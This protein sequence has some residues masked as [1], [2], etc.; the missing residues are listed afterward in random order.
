M[1][2]NQFSE[3]L[4]LERNYAQLTV[5][6]YL[7]DLE[8]FVVYL[9]SNYQGEIIDKVGYGVIRSWIVSLSMANLSNQ[10]INRKVASLKSYFKFLQKIGVI[11]INPLSRH[12]SL[13]LEKKVMIPFSKGEVDEVILVLKAN[14]NDYESCR[15]YLIIELFYALGLRRAELINIKISSIDFSNATIKVLGK[16]DKERIMPL[17]DETVVLIREYLNYY[18]LK[19]KIEKNSYLFLTNKGV[20]IYESFVFR[21]VNSYFSKVSVKIKKSPHILRHSFA[22]HLLS[23]GAELNAVKELLGH[24]SLAATQ[25]YTNNDIDQLAKVYKGAHPRNR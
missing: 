12:K 7:A 14:C 22:T 2:L 1:Y 11:A 17:L 8:S 23:R 6:A 20:K 25:I 5:K 21:L 16:R 9:N 15:D 18:K 24:S 19:Y 3:Y 13:K 10:T 4:L